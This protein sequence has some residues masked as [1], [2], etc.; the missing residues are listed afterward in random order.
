[1]ASVVIGDTVSGVMDDLI[2]EGSSVQVTDA[3]VDA[4][5]FPGS[6]FS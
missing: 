1:L 5:D 4:L 3:F 6:G 2:R